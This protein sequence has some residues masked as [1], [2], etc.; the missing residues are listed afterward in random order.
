MRLSLM[1]SDYLCARTTEGNVIVVLREARMVCEG[2]S[3]LRKGSKAWREK[4]YWTRDPNEYHHLYDARKSPFLKD[5]EWISAESK[6]QAI[7]VYKC[8]LNSNSI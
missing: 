5:V 7:E 6:E 1:K 3:Y 8:Q 4:G 2:P